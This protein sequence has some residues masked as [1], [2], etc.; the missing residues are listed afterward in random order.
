MVAATMEEER[1]S[2]VRRAIDLVLAALPSRS[3]NHSSAIQQVCLWYCLLCNRRG[4][5]RG[6]FLYESSSDSRLTDAQSIS[7][8]SYLKGASSLWSRSTL[9]SNYTF[10]ASSSSSA[11]PNSVQIGV[12]NVTSAKSKTTGKTASIWEYEKPRGLPDRALE[13]LRKEASSL[14]RLRHPCILEMVEPVEETRSLITFATEPVT[15]SLR[16]AIRSGRAK[17]EDG[18]L[19]DVEVGFHFLRCSLLY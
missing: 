7:M 9:A 4:L 11:S 3:T 6:E 18:D 13:V 2:K 17:E 5:Y 8:A 10:V 15:S 16:E 12:W 14:G 1:D 19:D